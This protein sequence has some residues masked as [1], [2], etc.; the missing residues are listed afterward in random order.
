[1]TKITLP[2]WLQSEEKGSLKMK[3]EGKNG[4][5]RTHAET[6]P[7][8]TPGPVVAENGSSTS[9]MILLAK[10]IT[11]ETEK[12]DKYLKENGLPDPGFTVDAPGDFPK[13]PDDIQRSRQKIVYAT[14]ELGAL[15]R[16]PR[17]S[18][19]WGVWG[20]SEMTSRQLVLA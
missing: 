14:K 6:G 11:E 13:L 12:L 4:A 9:Q 7:S 5:V 2:T 16:G 3:D 20:V 19:R 17:E 10:R 1:M 15:V 18:V 8:S